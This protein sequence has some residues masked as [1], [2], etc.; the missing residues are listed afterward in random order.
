MNGTILVVDDSLTVRSDLVDAFVAG[1]MPALGCADAAQARVALASERVGLVI[2][3]VVLPDGDGIDLL[4]EIRA[5][6]NGDIPILMLSTESEVRDRI[7][8]LTTGADDYVGKPYDRDYLVARARELLERARRVSGA[9]QPTVLVIDDS[10]TY[11]ERLAEALREQ[12]F[13]VLTA[14]SGEEGLRSAAAHRPQ[15]VIVDGML[16]GIDGSTVVRRLRLDAAL[17]QTRCILLTGAGDRSAELR[18]L[19]SGA[20]AFVR[21]E[22][23]LDMLLARVGAV[24]RS[25]DSVAG[26]EAASLLGPK[27]ILA[28]DDSMTYLEELASTM[29]GEGYDVI[30]ARSGEEALEM[31]AAQPVDCIL[32]DRI[33]PGIGGTETC[34]RIKSSPVERDIPL[35]MLTAAEDREAMI[36]G[37]ST[38]A[39]DYVLKSSEIEVLK[40]RVRAQLRRKQIEDEGRRIRVELLNKEMEAAQARAARDL[41]ESRAE[42]LA[43]L[44][45]KNRDLEHAVDELRKRQLEVA[46]TN[47]QLEA[48]NR[49]K[50]EFLAT[51]SHELRTPLN[52]I[53]G[54]SSLLKE[55]MAGELAPKHATFVGHIHNSGQHLLELI[56]EI[57][58][59][60]KIEAGKVELELET[61]DLDP[62]LN[63]ALV[64]V[65][66]R[67]RVRRIELEVHA[68]GLEQPFVADR[69]RLKQIVFNLLSNA[70]KFSSENGKVSLQAALVDRSRAANALPGFEQGAR[71][72]LPDNEFQQFVEIAVSDAGIGI[73]AE[74]L[75][76]LFKP[77]TQIKTPVTRTI[78]GTG[79]GLATVLRL[80][81]L[82]GGTVAVTSAPGRGSCFTVW[83]PWRLVEVDAPVA[84]VSAYTLGP[85]KPLALLIEDNEQAAVLLRLHLEAEGFRVHWEP[86]AEAALQQVVNLV[87][88]L[89]TLDIMLPGID[90]WE[91]LARIKETRAW[92]G[93]PVVVVSVSAERGIALSL[94]AASML[95][96]PFS[97]E[98]LVRDLERLGLKPA[99]ARA[100]T[101]LVIDDDPQAVELSSAYLSQ[102]GYA[103]VPAYGGEEGL[104][105]ARQIVPDL[106]VLDL[107]MP[108]MSG[109]EVVEKLRLV[110]ETARIPVIMV[111]A[112]EFTAQERAQLK[113]HVS[114]VMSKADFERNAFIGEVRRAF[115]RA[116]A[117]SGSGDP[118]AP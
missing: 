107:L 93:I 82:H 61:V 46:E 34:R 29:R 11:R 37:L 23:D 71:L 102:L 7:R 92:S 9:S 103:V 15:A 106:I 118:P 83:L 51:M 54:F 8:G 22:E 104:A 49:A 24:L 41:A 75:E 86:S 110:P 87:P 16:P 78:E 40:A 52:A 45:R 67:A 91:F 27:R 13:D 47:R 58:D 5:G 35:I 109:I 94:G 25:V 62:L 64:I 76:Q 20:D 108:G 12:G 74:A 48:A 43:I 117:E 81:Q 84:V 26:S 105:S 89:I 4:R 112:K 18:A 21:K 42:L 55:G 1:G 32:L 56:N 96:K 90:G 79:L 115:V 113:G 69:R 50:S 33:M 80:V 30:L 116:T 98:E 99:P 3:D 59:L 97:R 57:L 44:E 10:A 111:T 70:V 100:L 73:A 2:L 88:D 6:E 31:L 39:D 68:P 38:G 66:E 36:E 72:P 63:D 19:D 114:S 60:S 77:F 85:E 17:R 28:V 101:V 14:A 65:R 53:I 95:Q